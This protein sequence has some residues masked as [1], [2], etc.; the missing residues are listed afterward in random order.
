[1]T[2]HGHKNK[3]KLEV[4]TRQMLMRMVMLWNNFPWGQS[5][6]EGLRAEGH[7]KAWATVYDLAWR[8]IL[9]L[10][11]QEPFHNLGTLSSELLYNQKLVKRCFNYAN[12]YCDKLKQAFNTVTTRIHKH[13]HWHLKTSLYRIAHRKWRFILKSI[14]QQHKMPKYIYWSLKKYVTL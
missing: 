11:T 8:R 1:M 3:S 12:P 9:S 14:R 5:V 10:T 2:D 13:F 6:A 7:M 4:Q